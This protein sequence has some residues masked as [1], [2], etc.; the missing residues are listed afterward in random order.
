M[1][2]RN[3]ICIL[4]VI[5]IFPQINYSQ[6]SPKSNK[7]H[8]EARMYHSLVYYDK[9]DCLV[10][11]PGFTQ[12]GWSKDLITNDLW[13]FDLN[14]DKW[15]YKGLCFT[16]TT[17]NRPGITTICYDSES[18]RFITFDNLGRTWSFDIENKLWTEM[19]PKVSPKARCGQGMVYDVESDRVVMFGG[20]GCT[21]VNDPV[22]SDTWTYD[23]NTNSWT[24]MKPINNPAE[25]M[26]FAFT[27]DQKSDKVLLWGGRKLE[28]ITDNKIWTYDFNTDTWE[29]YEVNNGPLKPL[30]YPSM[31]YV[32]KTQDILIFGGGDLESPFVGKATNDLWS[33]NLDS[34]KWKEF[35]LMVRPPLLANQ[36]LAYDKVNHRIILFGGELDNLYSNKVSPETW[37]FNLSEKK[38][39]NIK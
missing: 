9:T 20:F 37:I 29:S 7:N 8:P 14:E 33:F 32:D 17:D 15:E 3:L 24:E 6:N 13:I 36:S 16:D 10:L 23:F 19:F 28:P 31:T 25:R 39:I 2:K 4:I 18:E 22:F 34:N 11:F 12:H 1:K 30:A 26:Y 27:Y 35:A 38:W 21:A 5:F